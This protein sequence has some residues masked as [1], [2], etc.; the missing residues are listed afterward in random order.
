VK[1]RTLKTK[2][3]MM[4]VG[5]MIFLALVSVIQFERTLKYQK[6]VAL[7]NFQL[8][9]ESLSRTISSQFLSHYQDAQVFANALNYTGNAKENGRIQQALTDLAKLYKAYDLMMVVDADGNFVAANTRSSESSS[10]NIGSL[11]GQNF[12]KAIWF[13]N[14]MNGHLTNDRVKGIEGTFV[15]DV[16]IDPITSQV[17]GEK[18]LGNSFSTA[19]K[20]TSGKI[21]GVFSARANFRWVE[22][23]FQSSYANL[24][25]AH[26]DTASLALYNKDGFLAVDY[27]P[28]ANNGNTEIVHDFKDTLFKVNPVQ[29]GVAKA[30]ELS[31]GRSG[32]LAGLDIRAGKNQATGFVSLSNEPKM[33][34][35]LGWGLSISADFDEVMAMTVSAREEFLALVCAL[36]SLSVAL[37][38]WFSARLGNNLAQITRRISS[39]SAQVMAGSEQ[40]TTASQSLSSTATQAASSLEET[41]SSIEELST[42][43]KQ[44]ADNATEA[45][46]LSRTSR[47]SADE[48]EVEIKKL[49]GG[50]NEISNSSKKIEDIINVIDDIAFQTNL[51][52]LNAAVEAARAGDQGKG[53]AV[54]AEEVRNLAQ[55]SAA[56]AKDITDLIKENVSKIDAGV[57]M[58][59]QGGKSLKNI[60]VSVRKVA[61]LNNEIASASREQAHG[62]DQISQAMAQLDQVTQTNAASAEEVASSS[63]EM[64]N[65]GIALQSLVEEL[66]SIVYGDTRRLAAMPTAPPSHGSGGPMGGNVIPLRGVDLYASNP[67]PLA[68]KAEQ[69]IPFDRDE[70]TKLGSTSGF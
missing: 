7:G 2:L 12:R 54:V 17:F 14:V 9:A 57:K 32:S 39:T 59:D 20:D 8:Y 6:Q 64:S 58:A 13:Q 29:M 41:V 1:A 19:I 69:V 46:N 18:R 56:A 37:T 43:V 36:V 5:M 45:A 49:I 51:L 28:P 48:G 11:K 25:R 34:S 42:M 35:S 62:L 50:M 70:N 65:Q 68:P 16:Q 26:F 10:I 23:E 60:V 33:L 67:N 61:D 30:V 66:N 15:E 55:R 47:E 38:W 63:E 3:L 52:A 22:Q 4:T 27:N 21:I 24:K 44:N 53:F 40:L 31:K